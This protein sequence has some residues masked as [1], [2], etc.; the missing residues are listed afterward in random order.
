M[1]K[2]INALKIIVCVLLALVA[3]YLLACWVDIAKNCG[4]NPTFADWNIIYKLIM[5]V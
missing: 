5:S 4:D 2:I 1:Y 3:I